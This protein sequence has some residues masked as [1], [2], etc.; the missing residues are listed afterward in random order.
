M[1]SKNVTQREKDQTRQKRV[2]RLR[3]VIIAV[4]A[5]VVLVAFAN[6]RQS[7][8]V[9]ANNLERIALSN[10]DGPANAPV[11]IIEFGDFGCSSCRFWHN[12]G[13]KEQIQAEYGE[14]VHFVFRHFPVITANSPKAAEAAQCAGDQGQFWEYHDYLYE[15]AR[16]LSEGALLGYARVLGLD[17]A[18]FTDCLLSGKHADYVQT[19]LASARAEGAI[20][21]PTFFVN[22]QLLAVPTYENL[23]ALIEQEL[24]Q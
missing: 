9:P 18:V 10:I 1:T 20:G 16:D 14:Q 15:E 4:L 2:H 5:T 21:T 22:G 17:T 12:Q 3:Y 11:S 23:S 6:F 24:A 13:I 19:D 8:V 7:T